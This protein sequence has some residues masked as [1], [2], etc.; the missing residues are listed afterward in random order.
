MHVSR[1]APP[2]LLGDLLHAGGVA[3]VRRAVGEQDQARGR[4]GQE[5][6]RDQVAHLLADPDDLAHDDDRRRADPFALRDLGHVGQRRHRRPLGG[7]PAGLDERDGCRRRPTGLD[8]PARGVGQRGDAHEQDDRRG[9][10]RVPQGVERRGRTVVRGC[11]DERRRDPSVR[12]RDPGGGRYRH[13][14]R[15][16]RHHLDRNPV[17]G[18][19]DRLLATPAEDEG[20]TPLEPHDVAAEPGMLDE[21]LV[22]PGLRDRVVARRLPHVDDLDV[23]T[24]HVEQVAWAEPVGDDDVRRGE[25]LSTADGDESRV[26]GATADEGN[27]SHQGA[28]VRSRRGALAADRQQ[29]AVEAGEDRVADRGRPSRVAAAGDGHGDPLGDGPDRAVG[30]GRRPDAR[31][32]GVVGPDAPDAVLVAGRR[33]HRVDGRRVGRGVHQPGRLRLE[34]VARLEPPL[35]PPE[36]SGPRR[37]ADL[38]ARV[39]RDD[40]DHGSGV[41][42]GRYAPGRHGAP[43]HD[44]DPPARQPKR[45]GISRSVGHGG[46]LQRGAGRRTATDGH[47]DGQNSG[48]PAIALGRGASSAMPAA[49]VVPSASST[50][51]KAPVRRRSA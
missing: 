35:P 4:V 5:G 14:G 12:H 36:P 48:S 11:H 26:T 39:G 15:H 49:R 16:T 40:V 29:P 44:E 13:G 46:L 47:S 33:D 7:G 24:Q 32:V 37:L 43:A 21:D 19:V 41:Q 28:S 27:P 31:G 42:Q 1:P 34:D 8:Q 23:G 20:V 6:R 30:H 45:G 2:D 51:R 10:R 25:Q 3:G 17:G 22:D 9:H 18:A 50:S 38:G